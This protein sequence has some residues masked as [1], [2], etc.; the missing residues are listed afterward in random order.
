MSV[1]LKDKT[2][3]LNYAEMLHLLTEERNNG[4][5]YRALM[6]LDASLRLSNKRQ[7]NARYLIMDIS[8][9]LFHSEFIKCLDF[10]IQYQLNYLFH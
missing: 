10:S 3:A 5:H 2:Q 7:S 4:N 9:F 8:V 6:T 1:A